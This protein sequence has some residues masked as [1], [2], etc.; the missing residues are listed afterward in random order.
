[1]ADH[2]FIDRP[3]T[4]RPG[5]ELDTERLAEVLRDGLGLEGTLD[6][7]QFPSG[8]SNLT[9]LVRVG[10]RELVLRRPPFGAAVK[11]GHDMGREYAILRRLHGRFPVPEPLLYVEDDDD[12]GAPFYVME[13]VRGV[14]L[15]AE[16]PTAMRPDEATMRGIADAFVDTVA[17]LH[18]LD[19]Q[20]AGLADFGRPEGYVRRQV[21]GWTRRYRKAQTDEVAEVEAAAAWLDRNRPAESGAALIH[22][23]YKYDN[24][25][26]DPDDWTRV[27]AVLD[28]EMAT[29]GDPLMDLGSTLGYWVEAD[30]SPVLQL[31]ALS[32]TTLP[33]NP[34]REEL[35]ARYERATGRTVE[36]PVFYYV[37]G[38]F[39]LAVIVQQIYKRYVEGHTHDERFAGLL[40]AVRVCG[41]TA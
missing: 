9:Y 7:E 8:Y 13:R 35:V 29:V 1:M 36:H 2:D 37:Y 4:V 40:H 11:G 15:R 27:R 28:W 19:L 17:A 5:E 38:L 25:V 6:V 33:G 31:L 26:L 32:P 24:L 30:D 39:K 3:R 21:E 10:T 12:F 41:Q 22:N 23:D 18:G 20:A 34:T 14:I 16:M